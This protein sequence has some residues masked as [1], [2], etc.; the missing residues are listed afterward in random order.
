MQSVH[1]SNSGDGDTQAHSIPG[2][3]PD[4]GAGKQNTLLAISSFSKGET[5]ATNS[6]VKDK[7][8]ITHLVSEATTLLS[9]DS[10][11]RALSKMV[12]VPIS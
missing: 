1:W 10:A 5:S 12:P 9:T 8:T 6:W 7:G 3:P 2:S 11:L 4:E